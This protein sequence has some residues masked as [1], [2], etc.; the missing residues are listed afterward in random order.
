MG[1]Y[2]WRCKLEYIL[3]QDL[4]EHW[5]Q[6][7]DNQVYTIDVGISCVGTKSQFCDYPVRELDES[8]IKFAQR[9]N[10]WIN[11]RDLTYQQ[12][13]DIK[14]ERED[15]LIDFIQNK[16]YNGYILNTVD[17]LILKSAKIPDS[18]SCR[19]KINGNGLKDLVLNLPYIFDI[20][21]PDE[22]AEI[23]T[24]QRLSNFETPPF[25][26]EAPESNAPRVCVIDSGIQ[27]RHSLLKVAIDSQNSRS[28]VPG[29]IH[30]TA[31]Y[32]GNGGHGTR[33]AGAVLY[34]ISIPHNGSESAI[35][36]IQNAR[37]LDEK[38]ELSERLFPPNLL[39]E[40]VEIYQTQAGTRLFNHSISA[41]VPCKTRYMS[42]WASAIDN[43]TW[44]KDI[45]FITA[46]GNL[47]LEGKIGFTRL[48]VQENLAANKPYP[49]LSFR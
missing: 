17:G 5:H 15:R 14:S 38:C 24:Q 46:G 28:W 29:E 49:R 1:N 18:F 19:I 22:F 39:T 27:E 26:L 48:S 11:Q 32:V 9:V 45:L 42:A 4:I 41:S 44:Q 7:K 31:D 2:R 35:C 13:D 33:V 43:L 20:S 8:G 25:K 21:E 10:H 16:K 23:I 34:P 47:P 37:V 36:W 30:K 3:S 6:I 12:W 40:I